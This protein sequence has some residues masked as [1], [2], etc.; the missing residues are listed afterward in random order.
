MKRSLAVLLAVII[1]LSC[2]LE[3]EAFADEGGH[4][5]SKY[6]V[7]EYYKVLFKSFDSFMEY[8]YH[9]YLASD[10][11]SFPLIA[12]D[13]KNNDAFQATLSAKHFLADK[14]WSD[15]FAG[16]FTLD[17]IQVQYY[18]TALSC[19]LMT[20]E[21]NCSTILAKESV[22]HATKSWQEY[23]ASGAS[24]TASVLSEFASGDLGAALELCGL[25][26][27]TV[28]G[29]LNT[30]EQFQTLEI[31][32]NMYS[33]YRDLLELLANKTDDRI[34]RIA[35]NDLIRAV[36]ICYTYRMEHLSEYT[37]VVIDV[38]SDYFFSVFDS[39][40]KNLERAGAALSGELTAL[41]GLS[42][43]L[44]GAGEFM[45]G[46]KLGE[47]GWDFV[48]GSSKTITH[49]YE[50]CTMSS[51]RRVLMDEIGSLYSPSL[52]E[53]QMETVEQIRNLLWDL[54]CVT[55]F[56]EHCVYRILSEDSGVLSDI[57]N[58]FHGEENAAWYESVIETLKNT[59]VDID[60]MIPDWEDFLI[61]SDDLLVSPEQ[62]PAYPKSDKVLLAV[63]EYDENDTLVSRTQYEYEDTLMIRSVCQTYGSFSNKTVFDYTYDEQGRLL[64]KHRHDVDLEYDVDT[65]FRNYNPEGKLLSESYFGFAD[66]WTEV[67]YTY[68]QEGR[69]ANAIVKE[70][71][72]DTLM[73]PIVNEFSCSY[74]ENS[75]GNLV[76][77]RHC[78][79]NPALVDAEFIYDDEGRMVQD[80]DDEIGPIKY[81]YI[82]D[83][84]FC[85][86]DE[87]AKIDLGY[88]QKEDYFWRVVYILDSAGKEID[89]YT[90]GIPE[91]VQM[92][93]DE[94]GYLVSA[95]DG[96]R[97]YYGAKR[98]EFI[99]GEP[100]EET[101]L[102]NAPQQDEQS[103]GNSQTILTQEEAY[104]LA[105]AGSGFEDGETQTINGSEYVIEFWDCG[106][107][108]YNGRSVYVYQVRQLRKI[109]GPQMTELKETVLVDAIT[110]ECTV[111]P[112]I[113]PLP[114]D[115]D[116]LSDDSTGG[117][118][119]N[120][121]NVSPTQESH[122]IL[123]VTGDGVNIRS[124]PGTDYG[125]IGSVNRGDMLFS[126]GK[127]DNWYMV[128][129]GNTT[130]Y[131]I[132]DYVTIEHGGFYTAVD[133]GTLSVNGADVNIRS[134]P[135]TEYQSIGSVSS[136]T[137]LTITGKSDNWYQVNYNGRKGY[138]IEDYV[139]RNN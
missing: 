13:L 99:Y 91:T 61:D 58:W 111:V 19:L 106:R 98:Y 122:P 21:D 24:M 56:G 107:A 84:Y 33:T 35:A 23:I 100:G 74:Y 32:T 102:D 22:D 88:G 72:P 34:L 89:Q 65:L 5:R 114:L 115:E 28:A 128:E 73:P 49:Y 30:V 17:D 139:I 86:R 36:D 77:V 79:K 101:E 25:S 14:S 50:I 110:G 12:N 119:S 10:I 53:D 3:T 63:D 67:E 76:A 8:G 85:V 6:D 96:D 46:A 131:I 78:E 105:V 55:A 60:Y 133:S 82:D 116:P 59:K 121:E 136:G 108:G 48:I 69:V 54:T 134:G 130:G 64:N 132:E 41:R 52:G 38:E 127:S 124:G 18:K 125:S 42:S 45:L 97:T 120:P 1:A 135:G 103:A 90:L 138:I 117:E 123:T 9:Q 47:L 104:A 27:D 118:T 2:F 43:V 95:V 113:E 51:V 40:L 83:P 112:P 129:Y 7:D 37:D 15:F 62:V 29:G 71:Y 126:K 44:S 137:T 75:Q 68:D 4:D 26:M 11:V 93:Y 87:L 81:E 92:D 66:M 20:F 80:Y 16:D 70:S 57:Q 94:D 31:E 39:A 109:D